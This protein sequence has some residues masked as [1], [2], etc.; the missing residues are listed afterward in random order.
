M[1]KL[2]LLLSL[3]NFTSTAIELPEEELN[4]HLK[5]TT[6][7]LKAFYADDKLGLSEL[8]S[9]QMNSQFNYVRKRTPM[10][11]PKFEFAFNYKCQHYYISHFT[12][13]NKFHNK[14]QPGFGVMSTAKNQ[15]TV[16]TFS[17]CGV[18]FVKHLSGFKVNFD[19]DSGKITSFK[20]ELSLHQDEGFSQEEITGYMNDYTTRVSKT[21]STNVEDINL[22]AQKEALKKGMGY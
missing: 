6:N 9:E 12:K 13:E 11:N 1:K 18:D 21:I 17:E 3:M 5:T 14:Q 10:A 16:F 22:S 20:K 8:Q 2:L 19:L 15:L 4:K 7:W